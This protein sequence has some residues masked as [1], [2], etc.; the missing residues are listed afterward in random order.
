[1]GNH[2]SAEKAGQ[3]FR[4]RIS[5]GKILPLIGIDGVFSAEIAAERFE[6]VSCSGFSYQRVYT[7]YQM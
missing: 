7:A 1:M 3:E 4:K 2:F 5:V 6:G